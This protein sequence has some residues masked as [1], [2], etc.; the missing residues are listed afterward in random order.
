MRRDIGF[1]IEAP[2]DRVYQAYLTAA[3]SAPFERDCKKEPY[4]TISFGVN[5]SWKYNMNGGSC[6]I[7]FMPYGTGTAVNIRFSLAQAMGARYESYA[8]NL[9]EQ[10]QRLLM[11]SI[12]E[13]EYEMDDFVK[14]EN[15]VTPATLQNLYAP[16]AA[17]APVYQ[18]A[19]QAQLHQP[20]PQAAPN[21]RICGNCRNPLDADA[22]FCPYCGVPAVAPTPSV[23]PNCHAPAKPGAAFCAYCGT[24]L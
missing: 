13:R 1:Y 24:R 21:V 11:V 17:P 3:S 14:P 8:E 16:P 6:N 10:V 9:N 12:R 19:P 2:I 15:Q 23:C 4:H 22:R 5:Y 20:A 18:P 7:H